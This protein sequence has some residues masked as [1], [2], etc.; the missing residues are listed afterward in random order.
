MLF[1]EA[2]QEPPH[3]A[4]LAALSLFQAAADAADAFKKFL[5]VKKLLIRLGALHDNFR[6]PVDGEDHR[7][8]GLLQVLNMLARIPLEF[9]E[10]VDIGELHCHTMKFT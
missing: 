1:P 9:A 5:I 8:P 2:F 6:L 7:L 3:P 4:A 10:R